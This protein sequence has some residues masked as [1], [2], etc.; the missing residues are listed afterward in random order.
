MMGVVMVVLV[1]MSGVVGPGAA[2][3][4]ASGLPPADAAIVAVMKMQA[5]AWNRGDFDA[6]FSYY[7][8]EE[9]TAFAGSEGLVFGVDTIKARFIAKYGDPDARGRLTFSDVVKVA[10]DEIFQVIAGRWRLDERKDGPLAG[11]FTLVFKKTPAGW[12]IVY[13]HSS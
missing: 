4:T 5:A 12:R 3:E 7:A 10:G 9:T 6:F 11:R 13:D 1:L 2:T 8:G